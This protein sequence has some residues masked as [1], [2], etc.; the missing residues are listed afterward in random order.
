M[1]LK[2]FNVVCKNEECKYSFVSSSDEHTSCPSCGEECIEY[3]DDTIT[4]ETND[5]FESNIDLLMEDKKSLLAG[6]LIASSYISDDDVIARYDDNAG[7]R[8]N[9]KPSEFIDD[10]IKLFALKSESDLTKLIYSEFGDI[11]ASL[12]YEP[13]FECIERDSYTDEYGDLY[14]WGYVKN[15]TAKKF[16]NWIRNN[17]AQVLELLGLQ[18]ISLSNDDLK[19]MKNE[20]L[21]IL[22]K[23][24]FLF[25]KSNLDNYGKWIFAYHNNF[26][27]QSV[28]GFMELNRYLI[29]ENATMTDKTPIDFDYFEKENFITYK[30]NEEDEAEM[31]SRLDSFIVINNVEVLKEMRC[32]GIGTAMY[33]Y[34]EEDMITKEDMLLEVTRTI[35]GK[36]H[37]LLGSIDKVPTFTSITDLYEGL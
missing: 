32:Q 22:S 18:L 29:T 7:F 33:E 15:S 8:L 12:I 31:F 13:I 30:A 4:T 26:C 28:V 19:K 16:Y 24:F 3:S 10:I 27:A 5:V 9:L 14:E 21:E 11:H 36:K 2:L 17:E 20:E 25:N 6:V 1:E 34:M 23:K 35:D 37:N